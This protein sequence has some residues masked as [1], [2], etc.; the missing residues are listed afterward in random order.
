[1]RQ[2]I[3]NLHDLPMHDEA[4]K[5]IRIFREDGHK[6]ARRKASVNLN[7]S[8]CGVLVNLKNISALFNTNDDF[9]NNIDPMTDDDDATTVPKPQVPLSVYPQ[10]YLRDYGHVKA[11]GTMTLL[12]SE[13]QHVND[14]FNG[15]TA[16]VDDNSS[17][18]GYED[19]HSRVP[20][21]TGISTQMYNKVQHRMAQRAGDLDM[22]HGKIT[23]ML[24]GG[25]AATKP[26]Q[27]T[28]E[29]MSTHSRP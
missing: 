5:E 15:A 25:Q 2:L 20:V 6:I 28:A 13:I 12:A 22:Q 7:N 11:K 16:E 8:K 26:N 10:A 18:V 29:V 1:M 4:N 9:H 17:E 19:I 14:V 21:L 23:A 27:K 3:Q 24:A